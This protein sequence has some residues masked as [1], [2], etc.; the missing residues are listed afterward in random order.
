MDEHHLTNPE[1]FVKLVDTCSISLFIWPSLEFLSHVQKNIQKAIFWQSVGTHDLRQDTSVR[2]TGKSGNR[3]PH[4]WKLDIY[5]QN[6]NTEWNPTMETQMNETQNGNRAPHWCVLD[7]YTCRMETLNENTNW[8]HSTTLMGARYK[9]DR[10]N[11]IATW[12][13][14]FK[15]L[16]KKVIYRQNGNTE[17]KQNTSLV[18]AKY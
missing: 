13:P 2:L 18:G 5:R 7:R 15:L 6:G 10:Q 9:M 11:S 12:N 14:R 8:Q 1:I 17:W 3:A 16:R 4:W